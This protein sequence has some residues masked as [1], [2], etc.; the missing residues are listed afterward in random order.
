MHITLPAK[1]LISKLHFCHMIMKR[2][3]LAN[4]LHSYAMLA[5]SC[6]TAC[7]VLYITHSNIAIFRVPSLPNSY[8]VPPSVTTR[9]LSAVMVL[10]SNSHRGTTKVLC[11]NGVHI[12]KLPHGVPVNSQIGHQGSTFSSTKLPTRYTV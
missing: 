11:N 2:N 5:T 7:L 6:H 8:E 12:T 9:L 4:V 10:R 1:D 3:C